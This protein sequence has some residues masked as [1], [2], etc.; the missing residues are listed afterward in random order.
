MPRVQTK[1]KANRGKV[2]KCNTCGQVIPVG[3]K[4]YCWSFRYGGDHRK[5]A[6]CGPP[7]ASELTQ[8]KMGG[9]Y[10]AIET[11]EATINLATTLEELTGALND[12]AQEIRD[13]A[14]EYQDSLD[15]MPDGLRDA[16]ENGELGEKI[17][18]LNEFA[19][20]LESAAGDLES[21]EF[22]AS[23]EEGAETEAEWFAERQSEAQAALDNFSL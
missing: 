11:A 14:Q 23:D 1:T 22:E 12:C 10:S 18:G 15:N 7:K 4:F 8:S 9:A 2:Y 6:A 21:Q 5:C 17:N 16:A 20:E 13:V 19:D 3:T